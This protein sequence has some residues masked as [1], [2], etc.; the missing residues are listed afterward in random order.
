MACVLQE[1][2]LV[3][4]AQ[5]FFIHRQFCDVLQVTTLKEITK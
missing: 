1:I 4:I 5:S 2:L 3:L